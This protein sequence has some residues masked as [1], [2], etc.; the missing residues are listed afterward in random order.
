MDENGLHLK[1]IS[2]RKP[3]KFHESIEGNTE[4]NGASKRTVK[5]CQISLSILAAM[6]SICLSKARPERRPVNAVF[7]I[8]LFN[9]PLD[10]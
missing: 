4:S 3:G 2:H 5:I 9:S 8:N 1:M 6:T 7:P 10:V